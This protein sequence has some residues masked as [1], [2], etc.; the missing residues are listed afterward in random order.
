MV[1]SALPMPAERAPAVERGRFRRAL[2]RS[3]KGL[4]G[5]VLVGLILAVAATAPLLAPH[6]PARQMLEWR[7]LPPA[8]ATGGDWSHLLGGDNLG[9][10]IFSR[11]VVGAR[12]S[13]AVAALV[14]ALATTVGSLLGAVAGYAGG[15]V[16][17]VVMRLADFQLAFP[18]LLLALM[19]MAILGPGFWTVVL[20]LSIALWVN[21]ARVVRGEALRIRQMEFVEA[22]RSIGVPGWRIV[23]GHVLPN[24]IPSILVLA[25]LDVAL[26]IIAEAALSFLGLGV[27]PPTPSWG[28]MISEGRDF[29]YDAPWMVLGPGA[30]ILMTSVGINLFGDFLRD[31]VDPRAER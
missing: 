6:D 2:L 31:W 7:F 14:V 19:I 10:D 20:A 3:P 27:Q 24:V 15:A 8:W 18:F 5:L 22:A 11:V 13:I 16:D 4:T 28:K 9:R 17:S 21:F 29:L 12:T 26:V 23:L 1:E 30:V 25:T